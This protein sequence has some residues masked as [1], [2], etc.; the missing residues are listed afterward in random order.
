MPGLEAPLR[1]R[2]L[3]TPRLSEL[4]SVPP[5]VGVSAREQRPVPVPARARGPR[6]APACGR[7]VA[8]DA[9]RRAGAAAEPWARFPSEKQDR[10]RA[11]TRQPALP[12]R[13]VCSRRPGPQPVT[14]SGA[15]GSPLRT[16]RALMLCACP[17][18]SAGTEAAA[19]GQAG[20]YRMRESGDIL[21]PQL[22]R[23]FFF[24]KA[25]N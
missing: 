21:G 20:R 6:D 15:T 19:V 18:D 3:R 8:R 17:G 9:G 7:L 22:T 13:A 16:G 14:P 23:T 12:A 11:L 1:S 24:K 2:S 25:S 10:V 5:W 4:W